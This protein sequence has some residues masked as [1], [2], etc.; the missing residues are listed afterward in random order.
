MPA[1]SAIAIDM[2]SGLA[3]LRRPGPGQFVAGIWQPGSETQATIRACVHAATPEMTMNLPEGIRTEADVV[4][5]SRSELRAAGE[6]GQTEADQI[7]WRGR[8]YR[9]LQVW[10]R[11]EGEHFKA[12]AGRLPDASDPGTA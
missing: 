10:P 11:V 8:A 12:V 9:V 4:I 1:H 2:L 3:V 7:D 6:A 5:Y